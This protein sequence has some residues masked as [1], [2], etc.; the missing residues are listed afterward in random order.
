MDKKRTIKKVDRESLISKMEND[1][2]LREGNIWD[3]YFEECYIDDDLGYYQTGCEVLI[4]EIEKLEEKQKKLDQEL[5]EAKKA[6]TPYCK[7]RDSINGLIIT[8]EILK[9]NYETLKNA[10]EN[11]DIAKKVMICDK[12]DP[13]CKCPACQDHPALLDRYRKA[14]LKTINIKIENN[15]IG[16]KKLLKKPT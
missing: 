9:N 15:F 6:G 16:E 1:G 5:Y 3:D 13:Y 2:D 11:W 8:N 4:K 7:E 10:L 12:H 14:I